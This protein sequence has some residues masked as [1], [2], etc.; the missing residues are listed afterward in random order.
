MMRTIVPMAAIMGCGP[1]DAADAPTEAEAELRNR[2]ERYYA[3]LTARNWEAYRDFFWPEATL[4]TVWQPPGEDAPRVVMTS[5][6][7]FIENTDQ[8][9]DSKPI[10]EE[11]LLGQ[12][13]RLLEN[14]GQVWARYEA[15]FGDSTN[16]MTWRGVDAFTWMRHD[17]E[18]RIV[19]MAYTNEPE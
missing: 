10:F 7:Q 18:W 1:P 9:P 4:T 13:A 15:R 14:L 11:N 17:G 3:T 2:V 16:V 19:S 8:G 6:E 5:I 12:D